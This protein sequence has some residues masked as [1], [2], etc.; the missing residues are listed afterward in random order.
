MVGLTIYLA[1]YWPLFVGLSRVAVHRLGV[2]LMLA[3]PLVWTGLE[4][5]RAHL[6]T[7]FP[8]YFLGHTQH[9][10]AQLIQISDLVGAYGVSF[11]IVLTSAC[12]AGLVPTSWLQWLRLLAT[13]EQEHAEEYMLPSRQQSLAVVI[14]CVMVASA[15]MYG[16]LR[17]SQAHFARGPRVALVQ[18][19]F[20]ATVKH[21][22]AEWQQMFRVHRYLT[23]QTI[24]HR[25]AL[26]V[27][28]ET[29]FRW[30]LFTMNRE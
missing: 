17:R 27:W 2:P 30:P 24:P 21:D 5:F 8:W 16:S 11:L 1:L 14:C 3:A 4:F 10:W 25:P 15:A 13:S 20:P 26:V 19:N 12:L 23:G 22:P 6:F 7:G 28:P 29:M 9:H 18:G